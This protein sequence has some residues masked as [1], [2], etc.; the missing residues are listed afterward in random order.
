[1]SRLL[2]IGAIT[3]ISGGVILFISF[4]I[5]AISLLYLSIAV[6]VCVIGIS[7]V[8][9]SAVTFAMADFEKQAGSA[10]ACLGVLQFTIAA[11]FSA[12]VNIFFGYSIMLIGLLAIIAGLLAYFPDFDTFRRSERLEAA[13]PRG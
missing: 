9:P 12:V 1:M 8:T 7:F 10:A 3:L 13:P 4:L 5:G 2:E 6:I 11:L